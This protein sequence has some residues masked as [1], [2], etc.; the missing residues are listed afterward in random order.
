MT[1]LD[2]DIG[3]AARTVA[4]GIVAYLAL[5]AM[6]RVSG[7]RTLSQLSAFD[8]VITIAL[9]SSL[10]AVLISDDVGLMQ[11][12]AAFA[13][14]IVLQFVIT[15]TSLRSKTVAKLI[16]SEPTVVAF[17]G[18]FLK[19]AML[20]ERLLRSD[21]EVALRQH[22]LLR[23]E[24]ADLIVLEADGSITVIPELDSEAARQVGDG[25]KEGGHAVTRASSVE[26][27]AS[28]RGG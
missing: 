12:L 18:K 15:W 24:E 26:G 19:D 25:L 7:K 2:L 17:R 1:I 16:E 8:L 10:S 6:L 28:W 23:V 21:I 20:R 13:L 5:V 9:G 3:A 22:Q 11:G 14:L 27:P 4:V